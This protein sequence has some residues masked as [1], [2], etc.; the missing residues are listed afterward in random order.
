MILPGFPH[1][2]NCADACSGSNQ[3]GSKDHGQGHP[4]SPIIV[5]LERRRTQYN[6]DVE[7][8]LRSGR[9]SNGQ[10][11]PSNCAFRNREIIVISSYREV[12]IQPLR[13]IRQVELATS[14][15]EHQ[16]TLVANCKAPEFWR[17]SAASYRRRLSEIEVHAGR[18][19]YRNGRC[20]S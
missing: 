11:L 9:Y 14:H 15:W 18:V 13:P 7:F 16:R 6:P 8:P 20:S 4:R 10:Y 3:R 17:Y 19:P 1:S 2:G 5:S 12:G